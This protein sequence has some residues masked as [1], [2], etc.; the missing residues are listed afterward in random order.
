M[1]EELVNRVVVE[2][3]VGLVDEVVVDCM[4]AVAMGADDDGLDAVAAG[5]AEVAVDVVGTG[6]DTEAE[7][8]KLTDKG[9]LELVEPGLEME[10][11]GLFEELPDRDDILVLDNP[12]VGVGDCDDGTLGKWK[13]EK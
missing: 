5:I 11:V 2:T 13:W 12:E 3:E 8:D 10:E 7:A 4:T 9:L 1:V 6:A